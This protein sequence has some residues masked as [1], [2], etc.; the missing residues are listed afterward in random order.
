MRTAHPTSDAFCISSNK[1]AHA[2]RSQRAVNT[3]ITDAALLAA[4]VQD[5]GG[6]GSHAERLNTVA[7][8]IPEPDIRAKRDTQ[9]FYRLN[10]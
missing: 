7:L 6:L 5:R 10:G 4:T 2:P 3:R 8:E 9:S 1:N